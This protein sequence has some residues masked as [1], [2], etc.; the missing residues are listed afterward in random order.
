MPLASDEPY[1]SWC[2]WQVGKLNIFAESYLQKFWRNSE[3]SHITWRRV[4]FKLRSRRRLGLAQT[5]LDLRRGCWFQP[6]FCIGVGL[7]FGDQCWCEHTLEPLSRK[8]QVQGEIKLGFIMISMPSY[9]RASSLRDSLKESEKI[10]NGASH[11]LDGYSSQLQSLI[12]SVEHV[13][14]RAQV[15]NFKFMALENQNPQD[16]TLHRSYWYSK[17]MRF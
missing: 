9:S 2:L 13:A 15:I 11:V 5:Q 16:Q 3:F 12:K 8:S 4:S 1:E 10:A 7:S 6:P 14:D 17:V